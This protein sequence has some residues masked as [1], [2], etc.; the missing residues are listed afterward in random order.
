MTDFPNN[1][2]SLPNSQ[3]ATSIIWGLGNYYWPCK[4]EALYLLGSLGSIVDDDD[5]GRYTSARAAPLTLMQMGETW[6]K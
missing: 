1:A 6:V 3:F 2:N 5:S 4:M